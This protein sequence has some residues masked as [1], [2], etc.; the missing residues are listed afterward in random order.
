MNSVLD[1]KAAKNK[2]KNL[3]FWGDQIFIDYYDNYYNSLTTK[4]LD[5]D[6]NNRINS[7]VKV[8]GR[9]N[10]EEKKAFTNVMA[11]VIEH[12]LE[13]KIDKEIDYSFHL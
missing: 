6:F 5:R 11:I 8:M 7:L 9:L 12:Y 13:Q 10:D 4:E 2:P 1:I 3:Q